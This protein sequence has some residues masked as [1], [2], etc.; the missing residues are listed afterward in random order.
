MPAQV[1][2]F[3]AAINLLPVAALLSLSRAD[4]HLQ[5]LFWLM[6]PL[7]FVICIWAAR[8]GEGILYLPPMTLVIVPL[9]LQGLER[10]LALPALRPQA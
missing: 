2:F 10:R 7:W 6:V 9:A 8:L 5:R 3:F 4:P 1:A